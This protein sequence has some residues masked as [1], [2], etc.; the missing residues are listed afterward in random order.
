LAPAAA[1]VVPLWR[2]LRRASPGGTA[3]WGVALYAATVTGLAAFYALS[4]AV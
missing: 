1:A 4:A 3:F 2:S